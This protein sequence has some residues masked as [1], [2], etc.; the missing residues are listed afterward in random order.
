MRYGITPQQRQVFTVIRSY[1]QLHE[2]VAP[3]HAEI[4]GMTG[5][6]S[7]QVL[8]ACNELQIRGWI[9]WL[10]RRQRSFRIVD[11]NEPPTLAQTL[12]RISTK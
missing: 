5:Y 7:R 2:G 12:A 4:R 9:D 6:S 1:M 8:D 11:E 10:P 3:T